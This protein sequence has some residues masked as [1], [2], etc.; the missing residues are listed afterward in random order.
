METTKTQEVGDIT[1][2]FSA[3]KE[4]AIALLILLDIPHN[5]VISKDGT[6]T[7][8]CPD[9]FSKERSKTNTRKA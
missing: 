2:D 3:L 9:R 1:S 6:L 8:P 4:G 5:S 7:M